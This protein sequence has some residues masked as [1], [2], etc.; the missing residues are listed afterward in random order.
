MRGVFFG[1]PLPV[2]SCGVVPVYQKLIRRGVPAAAGMAFLIAT[3]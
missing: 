2:C 1:A 3:P